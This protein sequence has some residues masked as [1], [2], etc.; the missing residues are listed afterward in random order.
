MNVTAR[1]LT[2]L[3]LVSLSHQSF[4]MSADADT[5]SPHAVLMPK[6]GTILGQYRPMP[7]SPKPISIR[8]CVWL[9]VLFPRVDSVL[10]EASR[11]DPTHP[12]PYWGIAHAAGPNP[13]LPLRAN[14][15]RSTGCGIGSD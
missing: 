9:G 8:A 7:P 14:A 11:L 10:P 1:L 3:M 2:A 4:A 13:N 12:M 15:R 6:S 5:A